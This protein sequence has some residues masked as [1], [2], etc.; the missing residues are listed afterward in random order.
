MVFGE[1]SSNSPHLPNSPHSSNSPL[2]WYSC[3]ELIR[4][5][6]GLWRNIVKFAIFAKFAVFVKFATLLVPQQCD[7]I[8]P[9]L[10]HSPK[11]SNPPTMQASVCLV[12][13]HLFGN[14]AKSC[15]IRHRYDCG[16]ISSNLPF[17]PN[18]SHSPKSSNP[19]T[20]QASMCLAYL[21]LF[22][23]LAKSCQIRHRYDCGKV[24]PNLPFSPLPAFLDISANI[25]MK[26]L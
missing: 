4:L 1:I 12:Y 5:N 15:Q 18:L 10:S 26:K 25:G 9:N 2:C 24:S 21:H 7:K 19:P 11:L 17:S 23:N 22:G 3:L 14:L 8:L 13:L 16:K 20:W 6:F